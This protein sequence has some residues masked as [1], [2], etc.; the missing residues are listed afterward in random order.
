MNETNY[1]L[2]A[3]FRAGDPNILTKELDELA[4]SSCHKVRRR[5]AE[6]RNVSIKTLSALAIDNHPDVRI[7]VVEHA[8]CNENIMKEI[9]LSSHVDVRFALAENPN[10]PA[11]ILKLLSLDDNPYVSNKAN[12]TLKKIEGITSGQE[13]IELIID[14]VDSCH[15]KQRGLI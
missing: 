15:S 13:V 2:Q 7:A 9:I 3:Y 14:V 8:A 10:L 11:S 1:D 4:N 5:V 6:H 12:D